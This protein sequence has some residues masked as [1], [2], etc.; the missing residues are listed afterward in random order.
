MGIALY[1]V[2]AKVAPNRSRVDCFLAKFTTWEATKIKNCHFDVLPT[3]LIFSDLPATPTSTLARNQTA[4]TCQKSLEFF[5]M[6]KLL[7]KC[8]I[9]STFRLP[10]L[11]C[12]FEPQYWTSLQTMP[13][14]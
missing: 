10:F 7:D 2:T 5:S 8:L 9:L 14:N 4:N 1:S 12:H 6:L 11:Q 13:S 3:R